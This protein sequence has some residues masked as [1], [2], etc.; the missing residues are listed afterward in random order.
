MPVPG[1]RNDEDRAEFVGMPKLPENLREEFLRWVFKHI[2][3][4]PYG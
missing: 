4:L 2:T 1:T 3:V